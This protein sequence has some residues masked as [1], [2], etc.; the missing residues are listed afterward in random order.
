M[1]K[2]QNTNNKFNVIN[3]LTS[4]SHNYIVDFTSAI[5]FFGTE[6][7]PSVEVILKEIFMNK[8]KLAGIASLLATGIAHA[9]PCDGFE[10]KVKNNLADDLIAT[11]IHLDGADIQPGGIQQINGKS[12]QVFTVNSSAEDKT[13]AGEMT[14]HTVSLPSKKVSIKFTL[15]NSGL[16]CTHTDTSPA[17]D[18]SVE[19]TR[20]PGKVDYSITNK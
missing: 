20:L 12:E 6:F 16:V 10:I 7:V 9:T 1:T 11:K 18:Y 17:S 5:N 15:K 3:L 19:K 13:I 2:Q 8:F 4:A 14:F